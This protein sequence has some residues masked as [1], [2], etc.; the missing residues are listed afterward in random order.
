MKTV[1]RY[2]LSLVIVL[3]LMACDKT[4]EQDQIYL[5]HSSFT[6]SALGESLEIGV[7]ANVEW[8]IVNDLDWITVGEKTDTS[9]V[10]TAAANEVDQSRDG[11]IRFAAGN[12]QKLLSV[13]QLS[14]SFSGK[15][16]D[17]TDLGDV[18]FSRNGR[19]YIG[20]RIEY[21]SDGYT[22]IFYPTVVDS[23]TGES[24]EYEGIKDVQ[25]TG[26]ISD[27]GNIFAI[28]L[29]SG[30]CILFNNGSK[31]ELEL[32]G[33][34]RV[35]VSGMSA[36]GSVMVGYAFDNKVRYV[37]VRWT[38]MQPEILE[39]PEVR[40]D[41]NK[42]NNGAMARGCSEDG[43]VVYGSEWDTYGL[44]YW[45]DGKMFYAGKDFAEK[46]TILKPNIDGDLIEWDVY[47]RIQKFADPNSISPNGRFLAATYNDFVENGEQSWLEIKYPVIIDTENNEAHFIKN[48]NITSM[49]GMY[50]NNDGVCFGGSP[51]DGCS[52]GYVLD[53]NTSSATPISDWMQ[54]QYGIMVDTDRLVLGVSSDNNVIFGWKP[55]ASLLGVQYLGWYYIVDP[56]K[57]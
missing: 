5:S 18:I 36:D 26:A 22:A 11:V 43:S 49:N 23:F 7:D 9:I 53:Y 17:I 35:S 32:S 28:N 42:L 50:A 15:F 41:G 54:S 13:S 20:Y 4:I 24:K 51:A 40:V 46:K 38:N 45:R 19:Y 57:K 3:S 56:E 30:E 29:A 55:T 48:D 1:S 25:S 2:F 14:K 8:D 21:M 52:T 16:Q 47:C 31:T 33:C 27:D 6:F 37:P 34:S 12:A 44:I 10:I 39:R